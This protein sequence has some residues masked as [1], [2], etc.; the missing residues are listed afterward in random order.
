MQ[1]TL[2]HFLATE[3]PGVS[4]IEVVEGPTGRRKWPDDLKAQMVAE[5]L[6]PG[7]RVCEVARRYGI[8][9]QYLT[10]LR[11]LARKSGALA[12][13]G[14]SAQV[15]TLEVQPPAARPPSGSWIEIVFEGIAVRLPAEASAGRIGEIVRA[16]RG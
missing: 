12:A 3:D 6:V 1:K 13:D 8:A 7:A 4:R 5:T 10:T 16:L 15:A 14:R 11:S 9:P 2:Q